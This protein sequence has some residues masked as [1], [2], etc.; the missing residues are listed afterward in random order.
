M[1]EIHGGIRRCSQEHTFY[2]AK[3]RTERY[4]TTKMR[5]KGVREPYYNA[6]DNAEKAPSLRERLRDM[7]PGWKQGVVGRTWSFLPA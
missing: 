7:V 3:Y 2:R 5:T 4:D 1:A 6:H